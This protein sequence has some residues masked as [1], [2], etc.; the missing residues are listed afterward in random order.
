MDKS[1]RFGQ[2]II[3]LFLMVTGCTG[4]SGPEV[5]AAQEPTAIA[6]EETT[7]LAPPPDPQG[8]TVIEEYPMVVEPG[9]VHGIVTSLF[10]PGVNVTGRYLMTF[11]STSN[12]TLEMGNKRCDSPLITK[13]DP[14]MVYI[15]W[16]EV[17]A[18]W[19]SS[20]EPGTILEGKYEMALLPNN[21]VMITLSK[22]P[23]R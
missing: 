17:S 21:Q 4:Q 22:E 19:Q 5:S 20:P 9:Q 16:E 7:E 18:F 10:K 1:I 11:H 12:I 6:D 15:S 23:C 8:Q 13:D 2:I 14:S 3:V